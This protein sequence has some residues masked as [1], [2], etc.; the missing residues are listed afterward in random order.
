[1]PKRKGK[2]RKG[3][4]E[5][6]N[7][8][9]P[10]NA[11]VA[12]IGSEDSETLTT[13][14]SADVEDAAT[15]QSVLDKVN[16]AVDALTEKR[17]ETRV[18]ALNYLLEAFRLHYLCL[19]ETWTYRETFINGIDFVLRRGRTQDQALAV[20]CLAV[21]CLQ[22]D[23][24]SAADY[25]THFLP[26]L[27]MVL[28]DDAS[29]SEFRSSCATA[30]AVFQFVAGHCDV[31]SSRNLMKSFEDIFKGSCLKGDGKAPSLDSSI[32]NLHLSA[33]R[34]WSLL[35]TEL[36]PH[37]ADSVG[38]SLLP[39]IIKL[40]QGPNVDMRIMAGEAASII[41]ERIRSETDE[42]FKG[43]Y[44]STLVGLLNELSTDSTKS[45]SK[46]DKKK[47]R[48]FF[49]DFADTI[50]MAGVTEVSVTVGSETL[51]LSSCT[52]HFHYDFLCYLLK[53]GL[54]RHLQENYL[55]RELFDLG[56]PVIITQ[57]PQDRR[58]AKGQRRL[59][60]S[61]ASKLRTQK[62]S[63]HRD[64]RIAVDTELD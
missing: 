8:D 14:S 18:K 28:R 4:Q 10:E 25:F 11:S 15:V 63:S 44:Y 58:V 23:A 1:M 36:S 61:F 12:S 37:D 16:T 60:L 27:D 54:C 38:K 13:Y 26:Q 46:V 9:V 62:L 57:S 21:F 22:I 47:Q 29:A 2:G 56:S 52:E 32:T 51:M 45:R 55:V 35:Y 50:S 33:L 17:P 64:R 40:L 24:Q 48:H 19:D 42:R 39:V 53:S 20:E 30:L 31:A 6:E 59:E 49:R 43:P 34:S 3:V 41:Y 7:V 5:S